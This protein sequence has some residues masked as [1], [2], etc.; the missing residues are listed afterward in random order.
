MEDF[1]ELEE[2]LELEGG[3]QLG[4]LDSSIEFTMEDF[5]D[6]EEWLESDQK[7][8]DERNTIRK[9]METSSKASIDRYPPDEIDRHTPEYIDRHTCLDELPGCT[10]KLEP[11]EEIMHKSETSYLAVSEH[12]RPIFPEEA[13]GIFKR[14]NMIHD[15]VK[16]VVL[17]MVFEAES[18]IPPDKGAH[19]SY[20][21]EVL[22]EGCDSGMK[23]TKT[24]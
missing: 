3:E 8:H 16:I 12:L 23:S 22:R 7:L 10:V 19:L 15:H 5:I 9:D 17:C 20:Y 18:P 1:L 11:I 13:V 2:F 14:E 6:L 24:P 4:D 21:I